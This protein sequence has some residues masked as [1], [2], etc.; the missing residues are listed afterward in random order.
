MR[1]RIALAALAIG[2]IA[3]AG[4]GLWLYSG[5]ARRAPELPAPAVV[6]VAQGQRL[7]AIAAE[8]EEAGVVRDAHLFALLARARGL[9]RRIRTGKYEMPGGQTPSEVLDALAFGRRR[10][11]MVTIPEGLT[12]DEIALLLESAE[13]GPASGFRA[14]ARDPEFVRSLALPGDPSNLEGYLFPDTYA[15]RTS[16]PA[17]ETLGRMARRFAEVFAGEIAEAA[18]AIGLTAHQAVTLASLIEKEAAVERE[19]PMISAVFHNRLRLGMPLQSDPTAVYG[20]EGHAGPVTHADLE[21][22]TPH[23]TYRIAGLPPG[24]IASPGRASLEAAVHPA[25][26]MR[27]LYFVARRDRTHEF[28]DTLAEHQRAVQ[29]WLRSPAPPAGGAP[30]G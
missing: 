26:G 25:P 1:G 5:L 22:D 10:L 17:E 2:A 30:P 28:S 14:L 7:S 11:F 6:D 23:N 27:A 19:R 12:V 16:A 9:D 24:P 8:L 15:F 29:R 13:L 18:S 3:T 4:L 20:V 21:R